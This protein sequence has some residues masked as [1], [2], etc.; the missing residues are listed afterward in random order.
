MIKRYYI[1]DVIRVLGICK[2]T[3]YLWEGAGKI[4]KAKRDSMSGFR[5]WTEQD[6]KR[7]KKITGR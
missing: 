2:K 3:Y 4:P 7:L 5:Y 6:I 1:S